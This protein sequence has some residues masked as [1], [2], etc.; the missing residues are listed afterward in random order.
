MPLG[1]GNE[2][3]IKCCHM[4]TVIGLTLDHPTLNY[5]DYGTRDCFIGDGQCITELFDCHVILDGG[6]DYEFSAGDND[7]INYFNCSMIIDGKEEALDKE[8]YKPFYY[9]GV[10]N[11]IRAFYQPDGV[12][13]TYDAEAEY[14][15]YME[16]TL[17][18]DKMYYYYG[19]DEEAE[20]HIGY[21]DFRGWMVGD[22]FYLNFGYV[23]QE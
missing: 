21:L 3:F 12:S 19:M 2:S 9:N 5:T 16:D 6:E 8:I 23:Y 13:Y 10:D 15:A 20:Y 7:S 17:A 22:E 18:F 4:A 1:D 11:W 14:E